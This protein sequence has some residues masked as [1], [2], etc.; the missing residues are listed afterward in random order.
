MPGRVRGD[1]A[2]VQREWAEYVVR[3]SDGRLSC[4]EGKEEERSGAGRSFPRE[5]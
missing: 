5:N 3:Q 4:C 2:N 1:I